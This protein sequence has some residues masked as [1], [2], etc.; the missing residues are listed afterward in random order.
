MTLEDIRNMAQIA[1]ALVVSIGGA[2]ASFWAI[3]TFKALRAKS[4]ADLELVK[5][6][7]ELEKTRKELSSQPMV[8]VDATPRAVR[9]A[10]GLLLGIAISIKLENAG[11]VFEFVDL[12]KSSIQAQLYDS[13]LDPIVGSFASTDSSA[14]GFALWSGE[15]VDEDIFIPTAV[16]GL[17]VIKCLFCVDQESNKCITNRANKEGDYFSCYSRGLFFSTYA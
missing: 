16:E 4:K 1:Q 3:Y 15:C 17:Y 6:E 13:N 12:D 11:N 10:Q 5:L 14:E 7:V 2:I 8:K 9:D